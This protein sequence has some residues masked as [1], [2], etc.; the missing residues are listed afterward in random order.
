MENIPDT[1]KYVTERTGVNNMFP[2]TLNGWAEY[3]KEWGKRKGWT[4]EER[5]VPEKL[6]LAVGELS[7]AMEEWR[8]SRP[9]IYFNS[10]NGP[11]T[12]DDVVDRTA[13]AQD[14]TA[15]NPKPEGFAIELADC[16][17]R[18]LHLCDV[19]KIDMQ[20]CFELKM[21][22]NEKRPFRHGNLRA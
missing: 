7:E 5:D 19:Y 22:Y 9:M 20:Q 15:I 12:L 8:R 6:M 3:I 21:A 17:I 16:M 10:S 14:A 2:T 1:E 13:I 18:I 11:I 4:Y